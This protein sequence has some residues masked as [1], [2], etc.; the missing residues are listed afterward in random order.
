VYLVVKDFA[1]EPAGPK[2]NFG[3]QPNQ[4]GQNIS[5]DRPEY[6][7]RSRDELF[8]R[9]DVLTIIARFVDGSLGDEGSVGQ[10]SIIQ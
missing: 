10:P 8:Q 4:D 9:G 1:A 5:D 3:Q 6:L 7:P 2:T